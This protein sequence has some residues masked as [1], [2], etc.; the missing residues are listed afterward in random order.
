VCASVG[1]FRFSRHH[2]LLELA[3]QR[4]G[5]FNS[6]LAVQKQVLRAARARTYLEA[7]SGGE[8]AEVD[9]VRGGE[10]DGEAEA[11]ADDTADEAHRLYTAALLCRDRTRMATRP[12]S[13][14]PP[15]RMRRGGGGG[16]GGGNDWSICY[17]IAVV[18]AT[19]EAAGRRRQRQAR[20]GVAWGRAEF[21]LLWMDAP[22]VQWRRAA[23]QTWQAPG[24]LYEGRGRHSPSR[25]A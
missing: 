21:L 6:Q 14:S 13:P 19:N 5:E 8:V 18:E 25:P 22:C 9:E 3:Q 11:E 24:G 2:R 20:G 17:S 7:A 15:P 16:G 10:A 12:A 4:S 23:L 1:R